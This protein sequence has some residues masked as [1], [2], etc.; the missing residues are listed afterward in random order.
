M[1]GNELPRNRETYSRD[2]EA[3]SGTQLCRGY[4]VVTIRKDLTGESE[5]TLLEQRSGFIQHRGGAKKER[6]AD[7]LKVNTSRLM[8]FLRGHI[9][10]YR[11]VELRAIYPFISIRNS[12]E[13][14]KITIK[15]DK[16][17]KRIIANTDMVG[18]HHYARQ[19]KPR[20]FEE[21]KRSLGNRSE[22][23]A[24][25]EYSESK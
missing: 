17:Y 23:T 8:G 13:G 2:R 16:S 15:S 20:L 24:H 9:D 5:L 12:D 18:N 10:L 1:H 11:Q 19:G 6:A 22:P 25:D 4:T 3:G 21:R 14:I 7:L